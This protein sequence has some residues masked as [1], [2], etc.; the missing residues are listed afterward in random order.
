VDDRQL[1]Q[2]QKQ[3]AKAYGS[4]VVEMIS[5][6]RLLNATDH[7]LGMSW[8]ACTHSHYRQGMI[9]CEQVLTGQIL[10]KGWRAQRSFV[11]TIQRLAPFISCL[12]RPLF[13]DCKYLALYIYVTVCGLS[14]IKDEKHQDSQ[15][16]TPH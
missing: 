9:T 1:S 13:D 2:V 6:T 7:G 5:A 8:A 12:S 15:E 16:H 10:Y 3:F 11:N 4:V 14:S